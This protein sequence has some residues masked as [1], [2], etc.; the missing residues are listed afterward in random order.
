MV[1]IYNF[2][3]SDDPI[4]RIAKIRKCLFTFDPVFIYIKF[5]IYSTFDILIIFTYLFYSIS[6]IFISVLV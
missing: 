2:Y 1:Y 6:F 4:P 5:I 3:S